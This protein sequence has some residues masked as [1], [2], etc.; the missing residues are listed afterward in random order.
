[1]KDMVATLNTVGVSKVNA[2]KRSS[3]I[4]GGVLRLMMGLDITPKHI[5]T[6]FV[7]V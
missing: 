3:R 1:M 7:I 6:V 5:L 4:G 2:V